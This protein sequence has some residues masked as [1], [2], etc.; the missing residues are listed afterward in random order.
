MPVPVESSG[1]PALPQCFLFTVFSNVLPSFAMGK[2]STAGY[3]CSPVRAQQ[4]GW[5]CSQHSD[6]EK[7]HHQPKSYLWILASPEAHQPCVGA[8]LCP[9][10]TTGLGACL[11]LPHHR[12]LP[13]ISKGNPGATAISA[14]IHVIQ[15]IC[16]LT[17]P[18][19]FASDTA[20]W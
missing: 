7:L 6:E 9:C 14:W 18:F 3:A 13:Y 10:C 20:A 5:L 8:Q 1:H 12:P 15:D 17:R 2:I 19:L 4:W 16:W 11:L